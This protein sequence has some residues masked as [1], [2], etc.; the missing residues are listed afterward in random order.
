M[1]DVDMDQKVARPLEPAPA[2]DAAPPAPASAPAP[3]TKD[4][5]TDVYQDDAA[6]QDTF[7]GNTS[8]RVSAPA[9][10]PATSKEVPAA[11]AQPVAAA[12]DADDEDGGNQNETAEPKKTWAW[13]KQDQT[14]QDDGDGETGDE[15]APP[16]AATGGRFTALI[17]NAGP[18]ITGTAN[19]GGLVD[20]PRG[21]QVVFA[22]TA[23]A[24]GWGLQL[25]DWV[26]GLMAHADQYATPVAGCALGLGVLGLAERSKSG[27]VVFVSSLALITALEMARPAWVVGGGVALGLQ[28]AYRIVRGWVGPHGEKWPWKGVVWAAHIPAATATVAALLFGTN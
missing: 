24:A 6:D 16:P 4:W 2:P 12:D 8:A 10:A 21:P 9:A 25:D 17:R 11:P 20:N 3:P 19:G 23:Y 1:P 7:T 14:L 28:V 26:T 13:W 22:A 5:W 27:G 15:E 18:V